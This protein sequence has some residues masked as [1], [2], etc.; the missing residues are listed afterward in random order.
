[1]WYFCSLYLFLLFSFQLSMVPPANIHHH[2]PGGVV[3]F[4]FDFEGSHFDW[5][6]ASFQQANHQSL[7]LSI[8]AICCCFD[9]WELWS[10]SFGGTSGL[11][12]CFQCAEVGCWWYL[13]LMRPCSTC[14]RIMAACCF[15]QSS[16]MT[17]YGRRKRLLFSAVKIQVVGLILFNSLGCLITFGLFNENWFRLCFIAARN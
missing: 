9:V 15:V 1:M 12:A 8:F 13:R 11:G 7:N 6:F 3:R 4:S 2:S 17:A 14:L 16:S 10:A 5:R